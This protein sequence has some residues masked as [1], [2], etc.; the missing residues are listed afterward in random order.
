MEIQFPLLKQLPMKH[1]LLRL[2][3]VAEHVLLLV[4][5]HLLC[6]LC[7]QKFLTWHFF[8]KESLK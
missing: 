2:A 5:M 8:L 3:L 7:L 6:C 1:L 4:K